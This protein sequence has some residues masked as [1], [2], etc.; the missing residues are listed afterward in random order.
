MSRDRM[1]V[2]EAQECAAFILPNLP[3]NGRNLRHSSDIVGQ[4]ENAASL[5]CL[6]V[7]AAWLFYIGS[8]DR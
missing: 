1:V 3:L 8:E 2:Q 4:A 6:G 7:E 5:A